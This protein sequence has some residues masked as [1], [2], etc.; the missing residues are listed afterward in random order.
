MGVAAHGFVELQAVLGGQ[1]HQA[2]YVSEAVFIGRFR[3]G[4]R[5]VSK[6]GEM[7]RLKV[8]VDELVR[9]QP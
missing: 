2:F 1:A 9:L 7:L 8:F 4:A 3:Y 6:A 5:L